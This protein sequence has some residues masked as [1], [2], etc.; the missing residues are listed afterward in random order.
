MSR[1]TTN[2]KSTDES[3]KVPEGYGKVR[4]GRKDVHKR[5]VKLCSDHDIKNKKSFIKALYE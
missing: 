4:L 1:K 3:K 5:L 2:S